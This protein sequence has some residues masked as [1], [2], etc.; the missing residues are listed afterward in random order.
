M[1]RAISAIGFTMLAML[2]VAPCPAAAAV[3]TYDFSGTLGHG[4]SLDPGRIRLPL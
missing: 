1:M 3:V 2:A 4:P